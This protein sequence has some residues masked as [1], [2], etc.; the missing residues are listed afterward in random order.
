MSLVA[1]DAI[2]P[3]PVART[4]APPLPEQTSVVIVGAGLAGCAI[5][6][7]LAEAGWAPVVLEARL[8][9]GLG[10]SGRDTGMA[11]PILNDT[12]HRL[13]AALGEESAIEVVRFTQESLRLS[14]QR[15]IFQRSGV[16]MAAGMPQETEQHPIDTEALKALGIPAE[17][18]TPSEVASKSGARDFGPG[19]WIAE[20][21]I[22]DRDAPDQL[23]EM[24]HKAGAHFC[25]DTEVT[26]L[27]GQGA[28]NI[29]QT[30]KGN[31]QADVVILATGASLAQIEPW[32]T[33][34]SY[35]VRTQLLA[36]APLQN[37]LPFPIR[38]QLGHAQLV[39][40][41]EERLVSSGCRWA[42]A[43][44]EAG[45]A[46]DTVV[47]EAVHNKL[48]ELTLRH[49]PDA[50]APTHQWS[51]IMGFTCDGLPLLG[52]IPGRSRVIACT[53]FAGHQAA[54]AMGAARAIADGLLGEQN[55]EVPKLFELARF[56]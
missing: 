48:S 53:G 8:A 12:P 17:G 19:L 5:A 4:S 21:G 39:P 40:G 41:P 10:L 15:A 45:E 26:G 24:A 43:H 46:D 42:T 22:I 7:L 6:L 23:R 16:L 44:L 20:G 25:F 1:T 50:G 14:T 35:P 54:M 32:F 55:I 9:A 29:I 18:W 56:V 31:I 3:Q 11:M 27:R 36:S 34:K 2:W 28:D 51:G 30:T 13:I 49:R 47:S 38:T 37:P 33:D 52:P